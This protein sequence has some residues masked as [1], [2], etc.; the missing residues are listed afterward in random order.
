M[1]DQREILR[2]LHGARGEHRETR[3]PNGHDI[4][5][6]AEDGQRVRGDGS[7]GNM[8][9]GRRQLAG[10]LEHVRDHQQE[11]LAGGKR[12]RQPA[13]L[14]RAVHRAGSAPFALHL[15]D[16]RNT[17]PEVWPARGGPGVG[18]FSHA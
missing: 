17:A 11:T 9:D 12:R 6:I 15:D 7:R 13:A 14:Q 8:K 18:R 2:F 16:R 4:A 5:V 1:R 10:N 3:G